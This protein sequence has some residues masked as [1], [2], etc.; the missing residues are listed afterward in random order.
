MEASGQPYGALE[1]G[2]VGC[3]DGRIAFVGPSDDAAVHQADEIVDCAGRWITP[4][5]IDCHT[6]LVHG[7]DRAAEF[8]MRLQGASYEDIARAG[9]GIL[10]TVTATRAATEEDLMHAVFAHPTLSETLHESVLAAFGRALH[11]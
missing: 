4:G 1:N 3:R 5:L 9:G 8:E 11:A 7:G 6:H 10:S 2:A